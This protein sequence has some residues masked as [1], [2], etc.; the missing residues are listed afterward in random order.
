MAGYGSKYRGLGLIQITGYGQ[1]HGLRE[2]QGLDLIKQP[3]V[4]GE[5]TACL[6]VGGM[7]LGDQGL[8][9][10]A[11]AGMFGRVTQ[12]TNGCQNGAVDRQ[13]LY[14]WW[15]K[16]L[17]LYHVVQNH[18]EEFVRQFKWALSSRQIFEWQKMTRPD[19]LTDIQRAARSIYLQHHAFGCK[20][21]GQGF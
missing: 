11:D 3:G 16:V 15:L 6:H 1:L 13:T 14:A 2:G 17:T 9:T 10:L 18:L 12:R 21:S 20:V 4:A 5:A 8:S 19:T 7:V